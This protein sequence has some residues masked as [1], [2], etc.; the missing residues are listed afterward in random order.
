MKDM[1]ETHK[2]PLDEDEDEEFMRRIVVSEEYRRRYYPHI[3]W[4][5]GQFRWFETTNVIDL[6]SHYDP[7]ELAA[8]CYRLSKRV[9]MLTLAVR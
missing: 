9:A 2:A 6:W 5:P 4:L 1:A 8:I 7:A 3:K